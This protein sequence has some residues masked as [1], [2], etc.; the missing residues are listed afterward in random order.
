MLNVVMLTIIYAHCS[1]EANYAGCHYAEYRY[2]E[3]SLQADS[4]LE[5]SKLTLTVRLHKGKIHE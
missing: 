4:S 5:Q 2:A 3:L 1:N